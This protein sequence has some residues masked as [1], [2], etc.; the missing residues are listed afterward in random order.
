[1]IVGHALFGQRGK[2]RRNGASFCRRDGKRLHL[3]AL[4]LTNG[5]GHVGEGELHLACDQGDRR[6]CASTIRNLNDLR[7]GPC[8]EQFR[9]KVHQPADST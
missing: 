5:I 4:E 8:L 9:R 2:V 1:M 7:A 3:A 6:G